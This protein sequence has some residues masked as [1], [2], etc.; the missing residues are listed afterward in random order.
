[1]ILPFGKY[2]GI[3]TTF[4]ITQ[5]PSYLYW[6]IDQDFLSAKFPLIYDHLLTVLGIRQETNEMS[7]SI[8]AVVA[9][10]I[11]ALSCRGFTDGESRQMVDRLISYKGDRP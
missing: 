2:K 7:G 5:D 11:E 4:I 6:L 1:L 9:R 10:I 8:R 3:E